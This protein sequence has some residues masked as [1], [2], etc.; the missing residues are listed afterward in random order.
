MGSHFI[1]CKFK[2]QLKEI[3][4]DDMPTTKHAEVL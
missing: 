4:E 3:P 2:I 1:N